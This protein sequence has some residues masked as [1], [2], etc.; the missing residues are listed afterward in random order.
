MHRPRQTHM[1]SRLVLT[2]DRQAGS[3]CLIHHEQGANRSYHD[4]EAAFSAAEGHKGG[5]ECTHDTPQTTTQAPTNECCVGVCGVGCCLHP[6][7][8]AADASG[9]NHTASQVDRTVTPQSNA[10]VNEAHRHSHPHPL[11]ATSLKP[12]Y[13]NNPMPLPHW[14]LPSS[15]SSAAR[16]AAGQCLQ[17]HC[18]HPEIHPHHHH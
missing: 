17:S 3:G 13:Q 12:H 8:A 10:P 15:E 16:A 4:E 9:A 11:V 14:T 18:S 1:P 5:R 6:V 2:V 7:A